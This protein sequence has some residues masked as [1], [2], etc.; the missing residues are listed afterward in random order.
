METFKTL[1]GEI[2]KISSNK[3]CRHFTIVTSTAKFR[4]M[5]MSKYEFELCLTYTA[6]DWKYYLRTEEYYI[7]KK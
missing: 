1:T 2:I 3:R 4:T 7:V 6:N 5:S